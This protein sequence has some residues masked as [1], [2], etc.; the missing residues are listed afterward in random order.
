MAEI[1]GRK[2]SAL[3]I[4]DVQEAMITGKMLHQSATLANLVAL[5]AAARRAGVPVI[6]VRHDYGEGHIWAKGTP[7][8]QIH[9][10]LAPMAGEPVIDKRRN[11]AF[12][13][14]NL[15]DIMR[16]EGI[17]TLVISGV[18]TEYCI[19]A[20]VRAAFDRGFDLVVPA[21]ANSTEGNNYMDAARTHAYYNNFMWPVR[22]ATVVPTAEVLR[23]W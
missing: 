4:V 18:H 9:A 19:D 8:W 16:A 12:Y 2:T 3:L 14:T 1:D 20:T 22:Y 17:D 23:Q 7:G 15:E 11:S 10:P 5:L 13:A 6:H 21:D